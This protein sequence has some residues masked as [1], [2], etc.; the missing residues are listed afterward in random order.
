MDLK[1][2]NQTVRVQVDGINYLAEILPIYITENLDTKT[3]SGGIVLLKSSSRLSKQINILQTDS[4]KQPKNKSTK[5]IMA[6]FETIRSQSS[7]IKR[8]LLQ[9]KKVALLEEPILIMGEVG[10]GR[11]THSK[12]MSRCK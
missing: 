12:G 6:G 11:K 1:G 2:I 3:L 8:T 7:A 10:T 4:T 5:S 9:A